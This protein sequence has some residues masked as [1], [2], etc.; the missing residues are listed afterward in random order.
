MWEHYIFFLIEEQSSENI[1]KIAVRDGKVEGY[2][3]DQVAL[4]IKYGRDGEDACKCLRW[5]HIWCI[6]ICLCKS[7]SKDK[8]NLEHYDRF[9]NEVYSVF[10]DDLTRSC[11]LDGEPRLSQSSA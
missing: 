1:M 3:E 10:Q 5:N 4:M 8:E 7:C 6:N 9:F 11:N 2:T